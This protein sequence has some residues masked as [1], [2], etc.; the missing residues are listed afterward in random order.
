[1]MLDMNKYNMPELQELDLSYNQIVGLD[2]RGGNYGK[3]RSLKAQWN[4][5]EYFLLDDALSELAVLDLGSNRLEGV[6]LF[7][8]IK[9]ANL[10]VL[11]IGTKYLMQK[12]T[13][14]KILIWTIV[15]YL[16]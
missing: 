4:Q 12:I 6:A 15:S 1:M 5:I 13:L 7:Q 11:I 3:L 14:C 9:L 10:S 2:L 8:G 16:N